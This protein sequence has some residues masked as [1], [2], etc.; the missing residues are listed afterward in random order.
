MTPFRFM[1]GSFMSQQP[2][3]PEPLSL[4]DLPPK[5]FDSLDASAPASEFS[6]TM[7]LGLFHYFSQLPMEL[8]LHVWT[9]AARQEPDGGPRVFST[10]PSSH[11]FAITVKDVNTLY[12]VTSEPRAISNVLKI[13]K[14]SREAAKKEYVLWATDFATRRTGERRM[15]YVH[16][17]HDTLFL[18]QNISQ[19]ICLRAVFG[20]EFR[21]RIGGRYVKSEATLLFLEQLETFRHVAIDWD[22]WWS[23]QGTDSLPL[24][25][26]QIL[27]SLTEILIVLEIPPT[28]KLPIVFRNITAGTVRGETANLIMSVVNQNRE[29]FRHEFPGQRPPKIKVVAFNAGNES[30]SEDERV[31]GILKAKRMTL[32]HYFHS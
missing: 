9:A 6:E 12:T 3:Q 8:Q 30:S 2:K 13:C 26:P 7:P 1:M 15:I 11:R 5:H 23:L 4:S 16:R 29:T 25:W 21:I 17:I 28:S 18:Q 27:P 19:T 10:T 31:L 14:N 20:K 32:P 22:V 24:L